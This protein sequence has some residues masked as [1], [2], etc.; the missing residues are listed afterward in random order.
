MELGFC[1][2]VLELQ[3]LELGFRLAMH[4]E[5]KNLGFVSYVF[6]WHG[7]SLELGFRSCMQGI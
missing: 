7:L 6:V 4:D 5:S 2:R 1:L 3:D